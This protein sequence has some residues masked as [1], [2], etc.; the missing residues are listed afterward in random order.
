M[1]MPQKVVLR[2]SVSAAHTGNLVPNF[3]TTRIGS[4]KTLH[5]KTGFFYGYWIL[6]VGFVCQVIM[7]GFAGYSFSLYV[8]PMCSEFG[9]SR[10]GI[11]TGFTIVSL[12]IGGTS[13]MIGWLIHRHE[14]KRIIAAGGLM[15]GCGF[16]FLSL[17]EELWHFHIFCAVVG[18][19]ASAIGVVPATLIVSTWFN[20]GRGWAIGLMGSG[21]GVGGFLMPLLTGALL[22][23]NFGWRYS[24]LATGLLTALLIVPLALLILKP[25]PPV[26][27]N[28]PDGMETSEPDRKPRPAR[29]SAPTE[30]VSLTMAGKTPAFWF[31]CVAFTTF[32]LANG[33]M[34]WHHVPHL[35]DI[36]FPTA[37]TALALSMVGFGSAVGKFGF[38]WLCDFIKPG[39]VLAIGSVFQAIAVL[40]LMNVKAASPLPL[41]WLYA[42]TLGLGIGS[43]LPAMSIAVSSIFGL[44]LYGV[45]FGIMNMLFAM[46]VAIGPI[47]AGLIYDANQSYFWAF[48]MSLVLH[49]ISIPAI[50]L[51]GFRK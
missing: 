41:I 50:L 49:S 22:I 8:K 4:G 26:V 25:R 29:P 1:R 32:G 48:I 28:G 15:L 21:I 9:W 38:G 31:M 35:A 20:K 17:T 33:A 46:A 42:L 43:W 23:P 3:Q 10:T 16:A 27:E 45:V 6:T 24:L 13:P 11:M 18:I 12:L 14:A 7:N 51:V 36:G 37:I 44:G 19:G 39:Y 34:F 5:E 40:T 2:A 30:F 47:F